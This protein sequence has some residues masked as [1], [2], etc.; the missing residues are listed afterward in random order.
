MATIAID[1]DGV[2]HKYSKGWHDGSCYD[3]PMEGFIDALRILSKKYA[4]Y[5]FSTRPADSIRAWWE[6][7]IGSEFET[8]ILRPEDGVRSWDQRGIIGISNVKLPAIAY[9][10]DRA[11][12]FTNWMDVRKYF[13]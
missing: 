6:S 7:H 12:R 13:N 2:V 5:V 1:F 8:Q 3:E 9:I 10:D 4:I 11:I